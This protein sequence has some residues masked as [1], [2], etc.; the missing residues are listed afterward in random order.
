VTDISFQGPEYFNADLECHKNG[1]GVAS[2]LTGYA[3]V[4]VAI[5]HN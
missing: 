5:E 4:E 3:F 2:E 1:H